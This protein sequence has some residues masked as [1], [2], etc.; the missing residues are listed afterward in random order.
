[1]IVS[2]LQLGTEE[3]IAAGSLWKQFLGQ[4]KLFSSESGQAAHRQVPGH[5]DEFRAIANDPWCGF[6]SEANDECRQEPQEAEPGP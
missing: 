2:R 6:Q 5:C 3:S 4:P 1:M